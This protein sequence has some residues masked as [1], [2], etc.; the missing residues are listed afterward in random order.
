MATNLP[1]RHRW[2]APSRSAAGGTLT[3]NRQALAASPG[4]SLDA[5]TRSFMERGFGHDFSR[6]RVHDSPRLAGSARVLGAR[7]Y[8]VGQDVVFGAGELRPG[9][10]A[11]RQLL[12]HEL[13]HVVQQSGAGSGSGARVPLADAGH[14]AEGEAVRAGLAVAAGGAFQVAES[15]PVQAA[16]SPLDIAAIRQDITDGLSTPPELF[17]WL[18]VTGER[19]GE[20]GF[21]ASPPPRG[22]AFSP[23]PVPTDPSRP[24]DAF[25]FPSYLRHHEQRALV[26]GGFHGNE[27]PG[28]EIADAL[29]AEL[30][31]NAV[32]LAFHTL[33]VPRV[34]PGGIAANSRCNPQ[35]VDLNRNFPTGTPG[36]SPVCTNTGA[37]P[38][39]P[40][41]AAVRQLIASFQPHRI[42]SAHS[43]SNPAE[44][45]V[46]ADPAANSTATT[47]AC[48]M[49][50]RVL[51]PKHNARGNR[52]TSTPCNATY[53]GPA[54]GGASFGVFAPTHSIP[55][56][57]VPVITLEAPEHQSLNAAG[58]PGTAPFLP[59]VHEFLQ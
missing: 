41:T 16:C 51:D 45:G 35:R 6:V 7:S 28:F 25:F 53:P 36:S 56:Q 2:E 29:V 33:V 44:A 50:G 27:N 23:A 19:T 49:A 46:Y 10:P 15:T 21:A 32:P 3:V 17:S 39:Q 52:L 38:E 43:I 13:A 1:L 4:R 30:Q 42:L 55:G 58:R 5:A 26:M 47:L 34:N 22:A 11:G 9:E 48:S 59:A 37:A 20:V 12:A 40:E 57:T 31:V 14:A 54:T 24:L 8:T 18:Q